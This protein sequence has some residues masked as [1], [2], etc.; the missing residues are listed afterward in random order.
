MEEKLKVLYVDDCDTAGM[1]EGLERRGLEVIE[2]G[3]PIEARKILDKEKPDVVVTDIIFDGFKEEH[4]KNF[5]R[6]CL[7]RKIPTLIASR[8][9]WTGPAPELKGAVR[10][11]KVM[12]PSK[13]C[14]II[15]NYYEKS[16]KEK[17]AEIDEKELHRLA[18][19][20]SHFKTPLEKARDKIT[21]KSPLKEK[22][23]VSDG[24]ELIQIKKDIEH[25][26][27]HGHLSKKELNELMDNYMRVMKAN[28]RRCCSG[29]CSTK[30][31]LHSR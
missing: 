16:K 21:G 3:N 7:E 6:A 24:M 29:T 31:R 1:K 30:K 25:A 11:G 27:R 8:A 17:L 2:M 4:V 18:N 9:R 12:R 20:D 22:Q 14:E 5:I 19:P 28:P 15:L 13:M 26:S 23:R 10:I